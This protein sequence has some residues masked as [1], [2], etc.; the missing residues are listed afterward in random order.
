MCRMHRGS[1]M[2]VPMGAPATNAVSGGTGR[3]S[4]TPPVLGCSRILVM[5]PRLVLGLKTGEGPR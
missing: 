4:I 5:G 2:S 3:I 1:V